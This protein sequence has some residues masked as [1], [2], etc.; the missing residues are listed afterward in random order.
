[1]FYAEIVKRDARIMNYLKILLIVLSLL[2]II[3]PFDLFPDL[4]PIAG[5]L[6]DVFLLG[7]LLYYLTR[8][9]LPKFFFGR[10]RRP[11]SEGAGETYSDGDRSFRKERADS[12]FGSRGQDRRKTP[13]EILGIG[14]GAS[15]KEIQAAYRRA[16][17]AYH[18]DK[19]SHLGPELQELAKKKFIEIQK[20]YEELQGKIS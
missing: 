9:K 11:Q 8:G 17:Q 7:V 13:Y 3:S 1:M 18:P 19:V 12:T 4:I 2:Y 20:A 15:H 10:A 14:P 6:D 5:W 16:A